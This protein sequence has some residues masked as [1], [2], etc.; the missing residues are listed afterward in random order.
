MA[1]AALALGCDGQPI[2]PDAG[3]A[4]RVHPRFEPSADPI[5][6]GAV[7]WPDD[8]YLDADGRVAVGALPSEAAAIPERYPE[9]LRR[10]LSE[11]DGFSATA[12]VFFYFPP[13]ALD[14]ASLPD[15]PAASLREDSA[16]FLLDADPASPTAFRRVPVVVH[17]QPALGQLALRPYDGH[18]LTPGRRYA[19]VVTTAV[20][21]DAGMPI[22]PDPRFAAIRDA[23]GRPEDPVQAEAYDRYTPV[24]ASLASNGTPR[25][26]VA[27]LTVFTVQ[28][29]AP[30]MRDARARVWEGEPPVAAVERVVPAG[31]PLDVLLG[32]PEE[33]APGLDVP[34]GVQHRRIG[35]LIHGSFESPWLISD[36]PAVHGRFRRDAEGALLAP[37]TER[38]P[39]TLTLPTGG[40]DRVP[41]VIFQHGLGAERSAMLSVADALAASG[42]AVLSI[43]IPFHGLRAVAIDPDVR[44]NYG[45]G[46]GPDGFGDVVGDT[47]TLEFLGIAQTEGELPAFHPAYPRDVLRQSAV[48][49]MSAVR[50]V[51]EGDW[52]AVRAEPGLEGL[53]FA[54]DPLGFVGE[55]LGGIV[56][57][58]FVASEPEVGAAALVVTGG[59][60]MRLV[61]RSARFGDFFLPILM[62]KVGLDPAALEPSVYPA[63]FHPELA[64]VSTLLDRGD[65]MPFAPGLAAGPTHLLLQMAEHDEL[66]PNSATEALAR[67]AGAP[68]VGADPA[69]TDLPRVEAPVSENVDLGSA[70]VTRGLARFAPAT[71]G[72]LA[73]R[74][75]E[76][77]YA[78]PPEPPFEAIDPVV[79]A[80]PVDAAVAQL[81]YFF[82]SWRSGG[83]EI[84]TPTP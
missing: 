1:C 41:L 32:V 26:E 71:H 40:L 24:L 22:G 53:A 25:A 60:L 11:L 27:A 68:I 82:E 48:D 29:V 62:P 69:H 39:F 34:G 13:D 6:F 80:N 55:S 70:R 21:D 35:W 77:R 14:P 50:L 45:P 61:E 19:A 83:A 38:V 16:V 28:T 20:R 73:Q 9:G 54:P 4:A 18:P 78:H 47:I 84:R 33:D 49:L 75:G 51:R 10:G 59:D 36:T 43:D 8:L 42:V 67:A 15:S 5:D 3:P 72:L 81:V 37:R 30:D 31:D 66:V 58:V 17:W 56:G 76:Q 79:V 64:I 23:A 2:E 65:A 44:H 74:A 63:S 46:E 7:P 52:G 57:T 12:P